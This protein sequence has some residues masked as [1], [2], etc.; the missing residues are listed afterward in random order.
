LVLER[1]A[2]KKRQGQHQWEEARCGV[3][4]REKREREWRRG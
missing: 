2:S 1:E 4:R 3:R